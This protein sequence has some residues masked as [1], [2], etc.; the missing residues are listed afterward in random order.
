MALTWTLAMTSV[1][2]LL[3]IA[4]LFLSSNGF[5]RNDAILCIL[6]NLSGGAL[7]TTGSVGGAVTSSE[8]YPFVVINATFALIAFAAFCRWVHKMIVH[9]KDAEDNSTVKTRSENQV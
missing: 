9:S 1:G 5:F 7:L 6:L 4:A 2:S 3:L 8:F